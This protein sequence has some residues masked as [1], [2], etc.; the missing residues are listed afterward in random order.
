MCASLF[1]LANFVDISSFENLCISIFLVI[2]MLFRLHVIIILPGAVAL[3]A[4]L[5]NIFQAASIPGTLAASLWSSSSGVVEIV[6]LS[7]K[8]CLVDTHIIL[9]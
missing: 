8:L 2:F 3:E 4:H 7:V 6:L 1:I 9:R 5:G